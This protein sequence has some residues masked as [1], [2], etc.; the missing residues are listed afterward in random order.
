MEGRKY[1]HTGVGKGFYENIEPNSTVSLTGVG[2]VVLQN[3]GSG[4]AIIKT[5]V[6]KLFI[7]GKVGENVSLHISGV[8]D[9]TFE[10]KPPQSVIDGIVNAGVAH[11]SIPGVSSAK[12][13]NTGNVITGDI[14][15]NSACDISIVGD[16]KIVCKDDLVTITRNGSTTTYAGRNGMI[17]GNEVF[18]DN[19]K[20][21]PSDPRILHV[22]NAQTERRP[23]T[24][25]TNN[26]IYSYGSA[27]SFIRS[28]LQSALPPEL[29]SVLPYR[30]EEIYS[31]EK[32]PVAITQPSLDDYSPA[33]KM[34]LNM[35]EGKEKNTEKLKGLQLSEDDE[36]S[37]KNYLDP[38]T[39][40]VINIPV[41]LNECLYDLDTLLKIYHKDKKDPYNKQE[42]ALRDIQTA[43]R[44]ADAL[45]I[46]I[47][48][49]KEAHQPMP[50]FEQFSPQRNNF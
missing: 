10:Q 4:T 28:A 47:Q 14:I 29:Q 31:P 19:E 20:V 50:S 16:N 39:F 48:E 24:F 8:G 6:G 13:K 25:N 15:N 41:T 30:R 44:D 33:M 26:S 40:E 46:I 12:N 17:R 3:V 2:N 36:R 32:K 38:I 23:N 37:L 45:R 27:Q 21:T 7:K 9:V 18:I 42:F 22:E 11:L 34:Y 43:R 35:F 49:I 1:T 5:G